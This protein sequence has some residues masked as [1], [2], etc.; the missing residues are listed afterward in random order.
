MHSPGHPTNN[1]EQSLENMGLE[2]LELDSR[3]KC[4]ALVSLEAVSPPQLRETHIL[5]TQSG[6][7]FS[8]TRRVNRRTSSLAALARASGSWG[9]SHGPSRLEE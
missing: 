4:S 2:R 9:A 5:D 7:I 1:V 8:Q 6:V 3:R